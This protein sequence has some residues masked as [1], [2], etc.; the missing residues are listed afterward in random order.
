MSVNRYRSLF[1]QY[2]TELRAARSEVLVWWQRLFNSEIERCGS[3]EAAEQG[4]RSR[5][6]FGPTS[7]PY[8]IA[9]YRKHFLA[10]EE[11][12]V[13][14]ET[15][16]GSGVLPK[17]EPDDKDWEAEEQTTPDGAA[18]DD[19]GEEW[20]IDPP[21]LLLEMLE[22]RDDELSQFMT[23]FVFPCI[24]EENGRSV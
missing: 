6:P 17:R 4:L 7:H 9:T 19:W 13:L 11:L 21:T 22:G 24:G 10:C 3:V 18:N 5:W 8:I 16:T 23:F 2:V 1:E 15:E 14:V 12:N 20:P